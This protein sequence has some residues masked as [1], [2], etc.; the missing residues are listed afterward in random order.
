MLSWEKGLQ[1]GRKGGREVFRGALL[2]SGASYATFRGCIYTT[3]KLGE[4]QE[5][6]CGSGAVS[7][8]CAMLKIKN[9]LFAGITAV[10]LLWA[11]VFGRKVLDNLYVPFFET[12]IQEH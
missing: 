3:L 10:G 11:R 2:S 12:L 5:N 6:C 9:Y 1:A 8:G 4:L 7:S